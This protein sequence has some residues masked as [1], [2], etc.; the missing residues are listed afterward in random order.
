MRIITSLFLLFI[1]IL[2]ITFSALNPD[3]VTIHYYLGSRIIPISLL[4]VLVFSSGCLLGL[5]IAFIILIKLK[6][7]N[8][9]LRQQLTLF[10]KE[11]ENLRAIPLQD[12]H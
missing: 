4:L 10:K 3:T 8:Y 7:K 12:R 2:G 1:V 9:R 5:I 11:V 6:V